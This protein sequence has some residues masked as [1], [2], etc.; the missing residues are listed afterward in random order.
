MDGEP[1]AGVPSA[2]YPFAGLRG[3]PDPVLRAEEGDE[4]DG[5]VLVQQVDRALS[6]G[7]PAGVVGYEPD[8]AAPEDVRVR[9]EEYVD[10]ETDARAR[11]GKPGAA[12]AGISDRWSSGARLDGGDGRPRPGAAPQA[13][14]GRSATSNSCQHR[15]AS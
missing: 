3:A 14:A 1:R 12:L 4:L 10:P 11:I 13:A 7:V 5:R 2:L 15:V 9:G 8:A 6:G